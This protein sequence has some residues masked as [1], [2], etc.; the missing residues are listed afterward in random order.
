[1]LRIHS[2]WCYAFIQYSHSVRSLNT[3]IRSFMLCFLGVFFACLMARFFSPTHGM[4]LSD[5]SHWRGFR[6]LFLCVLTWWVLRDPLAG[7]L[8]SLCCSRV[9][10]AICCSLCAI[11]AFCWLFCSRFSHVV[12]FAHLR[13]SW[14]RDF[15]VLYSLA[16]GL[17]FFVLRGV[18][19]ASAIVAAFLFF[20]IITDFLQRRTRAFALM[21]HG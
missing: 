20:S 4:F 16:F 12:G 19:L 5:F 17:A 18:R 14:L 10:G 21:G 2:I 9:C 11:F 6:A 3:F 8:T 7:Y 15:R 1:M 13:C